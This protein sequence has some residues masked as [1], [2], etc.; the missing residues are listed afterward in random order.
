M[1][2]HTKWETTTR[3]N[4]NEGETYQVRT[5]SEL[6]GVVSE[7]VLTMMFCEIGRGSVTPQLIISVPQRISLCIVVCTGD[8]GSFL[9]IPGGHY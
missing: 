3:G 5:G 8:V 6:T 9:P 4:E 7:Q 2:E 1:G